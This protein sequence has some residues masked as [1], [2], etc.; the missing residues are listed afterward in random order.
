MLKRTSVSGVVIPSACNTKSN[1]GRVIPVGS[2]GPR[3]A[4][5]EGPQDPQEADGEGGPPEGAQ[6]EEV[7]REAQRQEEEE[8]AGGPQEARGQEIVGP[9]SLHAK[10]RPVFGAPFLLQRGIL[11]NVF[12]L[13]NQNYLL[14]SRHAKEIY[15]LLR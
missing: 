2:K 7:L 12:S 13:L 3:R 8:T 15:L 11:F 5:R 4:G 14:L 1:P 6:E 10:R 9:I